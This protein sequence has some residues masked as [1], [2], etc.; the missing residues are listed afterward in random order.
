MQHGILGDV[1]VETY[2]PA[3]RTG[4]GDRELAIRLLGRADDRDPRHDARVRDRAIRVAIAAR[5]AHRDDCDDGD[6]NGVTFH[7]LRCR[8]VRRR[9]QALR[10]VTRAVLRSSVQHAA[11]TTGAR[12]RSIFV[13]V[14]LLT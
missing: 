12:Y 7:A 2:A 9:W 5:A 14:A 13:V 1:A 10:H 3:H 4:I 11:P 8:D 6:T